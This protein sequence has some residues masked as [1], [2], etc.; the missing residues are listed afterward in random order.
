VGKGVVK[1][2]FNEYVWIL[3][4]VRYIPDLIKNLISVGLLP[5]DGNT[6][7]FHNNHWKSSKDVMTIAHCKKNVTLYKTIEA[8]YLTLV[9]ANKNSNLWC[10]MLYHMSEKGINIMHLKDKLPGLRSVEIEI[11]EDCIVGK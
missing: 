4:N 7:V 3:K 9:A 6:I 2:K 10:Q 8:C 11:Y 1:I 5:S